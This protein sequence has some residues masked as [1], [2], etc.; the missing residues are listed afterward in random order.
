LLNKVESEEVYL[1][2]A[3]DNVELADVLEV[4]I[5]AFDEPMYYLQRR[6]LVVVPVAQRCK[7]QRCIPVLR[8]SFSGHSPSLFP[9]P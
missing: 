1:L 4:R 2:V 9:F 8:V 3:K 7:V 6:E 5:E